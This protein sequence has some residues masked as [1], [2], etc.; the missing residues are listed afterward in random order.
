MLKTILFIW[1]I[2]A[3]FTPEDKEAQRRRELEREFYD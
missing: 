1:L 2:V 3:L